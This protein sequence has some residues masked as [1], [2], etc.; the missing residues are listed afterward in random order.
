VVAGQTSTAVLIAHH[1][2]LLSTFTLHCKLHYGNLATYSWCIARHENS[3]V[4]VVADDRRRRRQQ[5]VGVGSGPRQ[6]A[7]DHRTTHESHDRKGGRRSWK[8]PKW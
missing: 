3:D 6:T 2:W 1:V 5:N 4:T 8:G 7:L